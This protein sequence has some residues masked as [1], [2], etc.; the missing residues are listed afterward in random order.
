MSETTKDW[1]LPNGFTYIASTAGWYGSWAKATDPV[2]AA[3]NAARYAGS[4]YPHFVS[5]WYAPDETT[6]VNEMGGLSYAPESA[7]KMVAVGFF[8]VG[9]N[10]IK[11]SK[12]DRCTH[13]EFVETWLRYF[14]RSNQSWLKK[15]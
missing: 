13:L 10:S 4:G 5:I 6:H 1:V 8:E 7:D 11:P 3:R 15:Q 9:K 14:D 12:D 2:T